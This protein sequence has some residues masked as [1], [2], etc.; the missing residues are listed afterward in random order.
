MRVS[1][2]QEVKSISFSDIADGRSD[3]EIVG[4]LRVS[5]LWMK[6][7]MEEKK[8]V[9]FTSRDVVAHDEPYPPERLALLEK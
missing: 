2:P 7:K 4:N 1:R 5:D 8:K 3:D 6:S 9:S